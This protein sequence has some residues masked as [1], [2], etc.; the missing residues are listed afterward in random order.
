MAS[1]RV[2]SSRRKRPILR[3]VRI[4]SSSSLPSLGGVGVG[5]GSTG[6]GYSVA[7][8]ADKP[9][10][11]DVNSRNVTAIVEDTA[12]LR[13]RVKHKGDRTVSWWK[14]EFCRTTLHEEVLFFCASVQWAE[15]DLE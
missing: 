8:G 12:V 14:F 4:T 2:S 15:I 10:F 6:T 11:D 1:Q 13:C 9:Y 3:R 7:S 5:G